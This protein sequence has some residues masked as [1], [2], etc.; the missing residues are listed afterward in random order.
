MTFLSKVC[1]RSDNERPY[2][3]IIAGYPAEDASIPHHATTKKSINDI[4][5]FL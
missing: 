1:N 3:L 2:M 4:A 5:T